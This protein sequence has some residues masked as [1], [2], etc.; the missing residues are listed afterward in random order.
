MTGE[1]I[2]K[3]NDQMRTDVSGMVNLWDECGAMCLTR[4]LSVITNA[5]GNGT[6]STQGYT[7]DQRLLNSAA[8]R[9]NEALAAG[10][11]SW[12]VP[13]DSQWFTWKPAP[14]LQGKAAVEDWLAQC[15][16][17]A[18]AYLASSNFYNRVHEAF[19]DW[20][21]F[22]ISSL[23]VREGKRHPLHC[24]THD[25]GSYTVAEDDELYVHR[26]FREVQWTADQARARFGDDRLPERV[27]QHIASG[28]LNEKE[29]YLHAIY[30]RELKDRNQ[31][32]GPLGMPWA[33]CYIHIDSKLKIEE[34]GFE[35]LPMFVSRYFRWTEQSPYGA[36]PAMLALAEIRGVNYLELLMATLGE[37]TVNPRV[38][39]PEG[40]ESV[41][42]LRAGGITIM[43]MGGER[44]SEWMTG[45]R[46]DVGLELIK[47]KEYAIQEAFHFSLF[48][49]FQQIE[50][51]ITAQEVRAREAEKLARFSPAFSGLTSEFINPLL[52][53]VFQLLYRAG[54]LSTAPQEAILQTPGGPIIAF[55]RTVHTS[56]MALAL[57]SLKKTAMSNALELFLPL[58]QLKPDVFDNLDSDAAFRDLTRSDGM[59]ANYLLDEEQVVSMR[60]A[61]QKAQ[62]QAQMAEMAMQA[63]KSPALVEAMQ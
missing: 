27:R 51:Q 31:A 29:R 52:E 6:A 21:T 3:L 57:Q 16:E 12:I 63:A 8:I 10:C 13:S 7:P 61:R 54:L 55:P 34:G 17:I 44:P 15:S 39:V 18:T 26:W 49:Q 5:Y 23:S 2:V 53:R 41:P 35:E 40:M 9:A 24:H 1:E 14:Q 60:E 48:Q 36:S 47:R 25:C 22:G 19:A 62:E 30:P 46:F 37:V 45:G 42:D 28:K 56:R 33:S 58:S 20:S 43:P 32:G 4:K 11:V 38:L 50:R 59:P